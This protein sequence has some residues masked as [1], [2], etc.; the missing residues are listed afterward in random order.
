MNVTAGSNLILFK[1]EIKTGQ[2]ELTKDLFLQHRYQSILRPSEDDDIEFVINHPYEFQIIM[3]N[4]SSK[5][6]EVTLLYQLPNGS[7]PLKKTKY[8]QSQRFV[9]KPYSTIS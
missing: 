8:T 3:T 7:I 1:K 9:L 2:C 5:T 6:K 4:I